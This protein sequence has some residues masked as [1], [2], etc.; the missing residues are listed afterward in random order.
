MEPLKEFYAWRSGTR[1][2]LDLKI[3][4]GVRGGWRRLQSKMA[5]GE[6]E[7]GGESRKANLNEKR[8]MPGLQF[9]VEILSIWSMNRFLRLQ[10]LC[11]H[12]PKSDRIDE[13]SELLVICLENVGDGESV[14][15]QPL[16]GRIIDLVLRLRWQH[17]RNEAMESLH[18]R[19]RAMLMVNYV[20]VITLLAVLT[21][22]FPTGKNIN[23]NSFIEGNESKYNILNHKT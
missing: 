14:L 1:W 2:Q 3:N 21:I 4:L 10:I 8:K 15:F 7:E 11:A 6:R 19:K 23:V 5:L 22:P 20:Q 18:L 13:L 9:I 16:H 17:E 12:P